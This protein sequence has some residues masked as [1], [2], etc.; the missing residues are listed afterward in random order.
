MAIVVTTKSG[1]K[2]RFYPEVLLKDAVHLRILG[3]VF[4]SYYVALIFFNAREKFEKYLIILKK[5]RYIKFATFIA[6]KSVNK[7]CFYSEV[8]LKP[9]VHLRI[10][11]NVLKFIIWP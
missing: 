7:Y 2:Y 10:L 11:G 8:L 4:K 9:I 6:A 1:N 5:Y 3:K